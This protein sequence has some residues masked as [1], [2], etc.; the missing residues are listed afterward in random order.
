MSMEWAPTLFHA[1]SHWNLWLLGGVVV[2]SWG[3]VIA[4]A[5]V[6]FGGTSIK[7]SRRIGHRAHRSGPRS[8]SPQR[9]STEWTRQWLRP[10]H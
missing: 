4:A 5:A 3:L 8:V 7:S 10:R 1:A 9:F 6:L 2:L